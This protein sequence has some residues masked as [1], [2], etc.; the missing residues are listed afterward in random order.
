MKLSDKVKLALEETR[1]LI[2]GAQIL[3]GV[4]FRGVFAERFD[5]LPPNTRYLDRHRGRDGGAR[6]ALALWYGVA[7]KR[8]SASSS[9]LC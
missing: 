1:I 4:G 8:Y 5:Q 6:L 2:L 7:P 3:L 9:P